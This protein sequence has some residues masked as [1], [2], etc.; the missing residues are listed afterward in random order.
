MRPSKYES[1]R[2]THLVTASN[3]VGTRAKGGMTPRRY[4]ENKQHRHVAAPKYATGHGGDRHVTTVRAVLRPPR[5]PLPCVSQVS[6]DGC[7]PISTAVVQRR[8]EGSAKGN[9]KERRV[10]PGKLWSP[11]YV[12]ALHLPVRTLCLPQTSKKIVV[13]PDLLWCATY[14]HVCCTV[15]ASQFHGFTATLFRE[16]TGNTQNV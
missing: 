1:G 15:C 14:R 9:K 5:P 13:L 16:T 3:V 10:C 12:K 2:V 11:E 4:Q 7:R 8:L 6:L